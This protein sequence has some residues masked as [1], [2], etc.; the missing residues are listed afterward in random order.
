MAENASKREQQSVAPDDPRKPDSPTQLDGQSWK[1][2]I[3]KTFREFS[4]DQCT[5]LAAA[6]TYYA[7]L[8]IFPAILAALSILG[9]FGEAERTTDAVLDIIGGFIQDSQTLEAIKGP[10]E[11]LTSQP[12]AGLAFV[13][14]LLGALWS[15]SGFVGAFSRAMNR[16]YGIEEGR[17]FLKLRPMQLGVTIVAVLL[18]TV[19]AVLLVLSGPVAEA[20]GNVIGLGEAALVVWNI[21][22]WPVIVA[23]AVFV[24]A[25]LY[26]A[27]PNVKQPKFKWT[28]IGSIVALVVWALATVGF[29]IYVSNFSN[30]DATYGSLGGVM[31]LLLW[32]WISN[33]ALLLGAELDSELER[34]RELQ[35][36]LEAEETLKLPPRDTKASDKKADQRAA[37]RLTGWRIRRYYERHP[38]ERKD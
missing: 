19:A 31:A 14:G 28:S 11:S 13:T 23:I 1:Y 16:I 7:V 4:A 38:E 24:L 34:G 25:L 32:I 37:D 22:K 36:G 8:A 3:K 27:A 15:A 21:A 26:Y 18:L 20:I 29:A 2:V 33:N 12:A 5:D 30:Y 10:V 9:L 17:G 35:A 6:L